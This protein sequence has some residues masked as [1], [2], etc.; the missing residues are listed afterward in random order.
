MKP[1][2]TTRPN[3]SKYPWAQNIVSVGLLKQVKGRWACL[4]LDFRF[5]LPLKTIQAKKETATI[6]G[7]VVPFQTKMAQAAQ[8][9]IAIAE[10][11]STAPILTV[12]D[13]WFGNN[14]LWKPVYKA[15][16]SRF[17]I[18]SRLRCNN[19]LYDRPEKRKPKQRG[20]NKKYGQ[21]L[22]AATAEN[23]IS[24]PL[25]IEAVKLTSPQES[26]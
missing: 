21:R 22:G 4:F 9:L 7:D 26:S 15:I 2:L 1:F 17:N 19:V 6:R 3:Q 10:H 5:Y 24:V 13:S 16:G 12:T 18:L 11:F 20:R 8:M 14:G 23:H 25:S